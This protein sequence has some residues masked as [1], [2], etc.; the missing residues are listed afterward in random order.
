MMTCVRCMVI[1]TWWLTSLVMTSLSPPACA[2][3]CPCVSCQ[4]DRSFAVWEVLREEEFSP[5]KNADGAAK[6]TPTTCRDDLYALHRSWVTKAGGQFVHKDGSVIPVITRWVSTLAIRHGCSP[7]SS[8]IQH[9][10]HLTVFMNKSNKV[11]ITPVTLT[12]IFF[13]SC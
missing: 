11:S 2:P 3:F 6:D 8:Y 5:L 12:S 10:N 13:I 7:S 1:P 9:L 4:C